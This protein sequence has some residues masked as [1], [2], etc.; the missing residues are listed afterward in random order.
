M[1][2]TS[3]RGNLPPKPNLN[4]TEASSKETRS[5]TRLSDP[6]DHMSCTSDSWDK[7]HETTFPEFNRLPPSVKTAILSWTPLI[8]GF[9]PIDRESTEY[10]PQGIL[11]RDGKLRHSCTRLLLV[12][13]QFRDVGLRL[14]FGKGNRFILSGDPAASTKWLL[15][16]P[17]NLLRHIRELDLLL[18]WDQLFGDVDAGK[19]RPRYLTRSGGVPK[20]GW[21][22][23]ASTVSKLFD[24]P[25][26]HLSIDA[27]FLHFKFRAKEPVN[28]MD[29]E[30]LYKKNLI[31]IARH[32]KP[33]SQLA[34]FHCYL[35][36]F[37]EFEAI[38]EKMVMG[39]DYD[40]VRD[41][42]KVPY[43]LRD[44]RLPHGIDEWDDV[45]DTDWKTLDEWHLRVRYDQTDFMRDV[46]NEFGSMHI[47]CDE[48][49]FGHE[50]WSDTEEMN[51]ELPLE[52]D[53]G[54]QHIEAESRLVQTV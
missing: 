51:V 19:D 24:I 15:K 32:M 27:S 17:R 44:P 39:E 48:H 42:E 28:Y 52:S 40:S 35:P 26:L 20:A 2:F 21:R 3:D 36:L 33:L 1:F 6:P 4:N 14:L 43:D 5:S 49:T 38:V 12:N 23:L 13:R 31:L 25:N 16:Q 34:S 47:V 54:V 9:Q 53:Q 7:P 10:Q 46:I 41:S 50:D 30:A 8:H 37:R 18:D 11:I 45:W 29:V 22:D